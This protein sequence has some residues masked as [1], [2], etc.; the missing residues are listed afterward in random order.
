M[1]IIGVILVIIGIIISMFWIDLLKK[2]E[3]IYDP[4]VFWITGV[5]AIAMFLLANLCF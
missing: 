2:K 1:K 3:Y 4:A 5:I